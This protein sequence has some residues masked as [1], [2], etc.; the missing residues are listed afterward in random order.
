MN[1]VAMV[2]LSHRT[3]PLSLLERVAVPAVR[4]ADVLAAVRA[5]G[6]SEAVLL[7]TCSRTEIYAAGKQAHPDRL[8]HILAAQAGGAFATVRRTAEVRVGNA[9]V[10]HL[11]RVTSGLESRVVGEP[12]IR[13]QVR[14]AFREACAAGAAGGVLGELFAGAVRVATRVHQETAL[15]SA[16]RSLACRAVDMALVDMVDSGPSVLVVGSGR[17]A[18]AAVS[19]L[20]QL[21]HRP[22][23]VARDESRAVQLAGAAQARPLSD[24]V[25]LMGAADVVICTTSARAPLLTIDGVRRAMSGRTAPLTLV[26]LSVPRNVDPSVAR[27]TGV[28]VVDVE[29]MQDHPSAGTALAESVARAEDLAR[30]WVRKHRDHLAARRAG[31]LIA[32]MRQRVEAQCLDAVAGLPHTNCSP[33]ELSRVARTVAGRLSHPATMAARAAAAAGDDAALLAICGALDVTLTPEM[34]G[35]GAGVVPAV[36]LTDQGRQ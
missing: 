18:S 26:D 27:I 31:P 8:V 30:A 24:L 12:E 35:L 20:R 9:A 25:A 32:A 7:V 11:V 33:E 6:F 16:A 28:R 13:S 15:G 36:Q 23:V 3:A 10:T 21:G 29:G 4:R 19:H 34:V 5:A 17:M 1:T 22:T 2:G 14:A